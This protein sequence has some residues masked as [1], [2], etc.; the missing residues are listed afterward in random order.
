MVRAMSIYCFFTVMALLFSLK[1][2]VVKTIDVDDFVGWDAVALIVRAETGVVFD[3]QAGGMSCLHPSCEGFVIALPKYAS[4][5]DDCKLGCYGG[6]NKDRTAQ[7]AIELDKFFAE[8]PHPFSFRIDKTRVDELME[9]WWP[10]TFQLSGVALSGYL[11]TG[12]CD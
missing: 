9:G 5:V 11:H 12:N 2:L 1:E 6:K 8:N 10:V 4:D 3:A 7:L